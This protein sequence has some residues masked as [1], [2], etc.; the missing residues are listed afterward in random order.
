[1]KQ[2]LSSRLVN[3]AIAACSLLCITTLVRIEYLNYRAGGAIQ[4][5]AAEEPHSKW[6][7]GD[8]FFEA[9]KKVEEDWRREK[10]IDQQAELSLSDYEE[11]R[12]RMMAIEWTPSPHDQL[13]KLLGSWGL[14]Q[15]PLA[16]F[17]VI[18]S[19][20]AAGSPRAR[21]AIPAWVFYPPAMIGISA[22]GLAF[23]RGY[24]TS[25]GW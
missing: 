4:S 21:G 5:K 24:F 9:R 2:R 17:L 23:Y 16:A 8:G 15:Y 10:G 7:I 6:R 13:G 22:L 18:A 14:L 11:I 25:L 3:W 20:G 19:L 12:K 1:M